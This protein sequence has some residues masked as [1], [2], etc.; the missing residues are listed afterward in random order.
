[1]ANA[2]TVGG[3]SAAVLV[4]A[5]A[6][7]GRWEGTRYSVYF[8]VAGNPT[9]CT[10]HL[11]PKNADVS[12]KYTKAECD[13]LLAADL[14]EADAAL[15]RCLPMPMLDHI[16]AALLS[17]TFNLGPQVVCGSTLQRKALANDWPG[18][19]AALSQW[20]HAGGRVYRGLTLR[21]AD[22]RKL[23]EGRS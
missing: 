16:H 1:V 22:E 19:C 3:I 5:G 15:T 2:R 4:I 20:D 11:L 9:V 6:I 23:C 18:A 12:R 7:V 21:R 13:A 17:A 8:D 14:A 10:G